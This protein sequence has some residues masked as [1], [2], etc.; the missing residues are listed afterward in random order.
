MPF[1]FEDVLASAEFLDWLTV[2]TS[3]GV[4]GAD[5]IEIITS[6]APTKIQGIVVPGRSS[7]KR[8]ADGAR[9]SA[10][11]DVYT[12]WPLCAGVKAS[13]TTN[14]PA[15]ILTWHGRT[16][17]VMQVEDWSAFGT[18]WFHASCDLLPLNPSR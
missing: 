4:I 5:G 17:T 11:I 2:T 9:V 7:T 3:S 6:A 8:D 10:Y 14:R 16:F 1:G 18:G 12:R 13:D 15:D